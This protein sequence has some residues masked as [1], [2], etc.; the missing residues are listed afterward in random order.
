[1]KWSAYFAHSENIIQILLSSDEEHEMR[2]G[3]QKVVMLRG[4]GQADVQKGSSS[5][6]P[7]KT[8]DINLDAN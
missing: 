7:R 3:V 5:V 1:M 6:R 4:D 2:E 8:P